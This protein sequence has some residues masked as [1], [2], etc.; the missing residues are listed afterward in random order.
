MSFFLVLLF[1][2]SLSASKAPSKYAVTGP[3]LNAKL[4]KL[5]PN[6]IDQPNEQVA[7]AN[8]ETEITALQYAIKYLGL[9]DVRAVL[10]LDNIDPNFPSDYLPLRLAIE[11]A[12]ASP[13]GDVEV[14]RALLQAGANPNGADDEGK[15]Q[16]IHAA[17][18]DFN[19][20]EMIKI[21]LDSKASL[22][23]AL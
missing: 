11:M 21:L 12:G 20:A 10:A 9:A 2:G 13:R 15:T 17:E 1:A 4:L 16:L 8:E 23:D 3:Q 5:F 19:T 14:I 7:V 6:I 22:T 18:Q